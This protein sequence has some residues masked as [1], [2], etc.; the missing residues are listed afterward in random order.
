VEACPRGN[1]PKLTPENEQFRTLWRWIE[2]GFLQRAPILFTSEKR[3]RM[4]KVIVGVNPA[5]LTEVCDIK[6]IEPGQRPIILGKCLVMADVLTA[7]QNQKLQGG[8]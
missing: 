1:V 8:G 2:P 3:T 4:E 5:A 7:A 6:N